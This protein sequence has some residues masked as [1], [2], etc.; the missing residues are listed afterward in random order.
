MKGKKE[1]GADDIAN[2]RHYRAIV[3]HLTEGVVIVDENQRVIEWNK[4]MEEITGEK[5]SET[6]GKSYVEVISSFM[7]PMLRSP[8]K[9][10]RMKEI[11]E[12]LLRN[13]GYE[14]MKMN[15]DFELVRRDGSRKYIRQSVFT[16]PVGD[17]FHVGSVSVDVTRR[18]AWEAV[19]R[20]R[21]VRYR[22]LFEMA[23]DGI[24]ILKGNQFIECN[25]KALELFGCVKED[26]V[27]K[28]PAELS[29]RYQAD[30]SLSEEMAFQYIQN[31]DV[32]QPQFFLWRHQ[33]IDGTPFDAEVSLNLLELENEKYIQAIV[34]DVT[35]RLEEQAQ[36][37]RYAAELQDLNVAK[38]KFFSI[39]AHDLKSPF[40]AIMGFSE[41]LSSD[42]KSFTEEE[43][44][45]FI[46]N[47]NTSAKNTY[48]LLENLLE[49]AMAQTGRLIF[50][51]MPVDLSILA[52][53]VVITLRASAEKKRVRIF[54]SVNFETMVLADQ[55]MVRTILRNLLSNAIKF[56]EPG[57]QV[58][59]FCE[60]KGDGQLGPRM[61][62]VCV[63]D[64]G[65]GI[66]PDILPSLFRIGERVKSDGTAQEKGTGLGLI[67]CR[68]LVERNGG[69]IGAQ[70]LPGGGSR[71][72]FTLPV[73]L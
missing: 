50:E 2:L 13:G 49:W 40:N 70:N 45:H 59:V 65:V 4:A 29:P 8:E 69:T 35:V 33:R 68:E 19:L 31:V 37:K 61:V 55:N 21:E 34:R 23:N 1:V 28:T 36:L 11:T 44:Q 47:I 63:V 58:K 71:F 27:G 51:P 9:I 12:I 32:G 62:E 72:C 66:D 73:A 53:D 18:K 48:R 14:G 42:W 17:K 52:N 54:S 22:A 57:G 64:N 67:L 56:S 43:R 38:D 39:I 6:L 60:Y 7:P 25:S 10:D 3:H 46:G 26:I 5:S 30:G 16:I 15:H 24:F 20:Q 41:V